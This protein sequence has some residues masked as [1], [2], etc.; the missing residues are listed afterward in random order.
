MNNYILE[1]FE[2][3]DVKTLSKIN[4]SGY[5]TQCILG[6]VGVLLWA[7]HFLV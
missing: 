3:I 6:T 5:G 7:V 2:V 1:Q 4:G